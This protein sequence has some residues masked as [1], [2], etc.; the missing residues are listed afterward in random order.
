MIAFDAKSPL[1]FKFSVCTDKFDISNLYFTSK[2]TKNTPLHLSIRAKLGI[3]V[4]NSDLGTGWGDELRVS[5]DPTVEKFVINLVFE[6][7]YIALKVGDE[8]LIKF[9]PGRFRE[10][11]TI[12]HLR[13]EGGIEADSFDIKG[14]VANERSGKAEIQPDCGLEVAGWAFDPYLPTQVHGIWVRKNDVD[15]GEYFVADS[16]DLP[17][18]ARREEAPTDRIAFRIDLPG[19][20][21]VGVPDDGPIIVQVQSN[22]VNCGPQLLITKSYVLS[23]LERMADGRLGKVDLVPFLYAIEHI[24]FGELLDKLTNSSRQYFETRAKELN[25][26]EFLHADAHE[27]AESSPSDPV[28]KSAPVQSAWQVTNLIVEGAYELFVQ[29]LRQN[30]QANVTQLL[31]QVLREQLRDSQSR[32]LFVTMATEFLLI[33]NAFLELHAVASEVGINQLDAGDTLWSRSNGLPYVYM[34]GQYN[35]VREYMWAMTSLSG[36]LATPSLAWTMRQIIEGES[37]IGGRIDERLREEIIYAYISIIDSQGATYWGRSHCVHLIRVAVEMAAKVQ[38]FSEYLQNE[39]LNMILRNY[40]LSP[41]FYRQ[42]AEYSDVLIP[43]RIKVA[44]RFFNALVDRASGKKIDLTAALN[45]FQ[46]VKNPD[47]A[48]IQL[49]TCGLS[50]AVVG[51][52]T[53]L[54]L[55]MVEEARL[56]SPGILLRSMA[57]PLAHQTGDSDILRFTRKYID[58]CHSGVAKAP[59]YHL[60]VKAAKTL[61]FLSDPDSAFPEDF[62]LAQFCHECSVLCHER[63][64]YIGFAILLVLFDV[65]LK[66]RDAFRARVL[67]SSIADNLNRLGPQAAAAKSAPAVREARRAVIRRQAAEPNVNRQ[68]VLSLFSVGTS[69][70][71]ETQSALIKKFDPPHNPV[72]DTIVVVFSCEPYLN[73]RITELRKGWLSQLK[74]LGVPYIIIT[75]NGNGQ[76]DGDVVRLNAADNYE[77]LPE[78][79]VRAVEWVAQN[80]NFSYMLKIDDDCFL[81]VDEYFH[82]LSYR[83]FDYYGRKVERSLGSTDRAWHNKKSS[84]ER[85]QLELDKS[86]EPSLYA[87]GG[88]GYALSRTAMEAILRVVE[89]PDGKKLIRYSFMEDKLIGD[90]LATEGIYMADE[91]YYVAVQRRTHSKA[92]P[93][94]LW[95]NSFWPSQASGTKLVHLDTEHSQLAAMAHLNDQTLFPRKIW[96][97]Y[98][99]PKLGW[100]CN[101]LELVSDISKIKLATDSKVAVVA[102]VRNEMFMLP[103]FLAH[104]RALGVDCFIFVDNI[105]DDGT[106]EY[107]HEQPDTVVFSVDTEYSM[108][109][110]G[111]AWQQALLAELRQDK[112]SIVADAD[113]LLVYQGWKTTSLAEKITQLDAS[114][115]NGCRIFMLDMYPEGPLSEATFRKKGPFGEASCVDAEPFRLSADSY[116]PYSNAPTWTSSL[117]HR[118]LPGSPRSLFVAQKIALLKYKPWMRLSAGLHYAAEVDVSD[119]A[120]L[121]AHFKYN[122]SFRAKALREVQRGQHFNNAEEYRKYAALMAEGRDR[123]YDPSVSVHWEHC[124][125]V[126]GILGAPSG[127]A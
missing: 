46:T 54:T 31:R 36:W 63:S 55:E 109:Q 45:F 101:A 113:E 73:T 127:R 116:G 56:K 12:S 72:F 10:I 62:D 115:K 98:S 84:S 103:H 37:A 96:P 34:K 100:N 118:L 17:D 99:E 43:G 57:S 124:D 68:A 3:I 102:C 58:H 104:Y 117:R 50:S 60:Q 66:R 59:Y 120:M 32:Q 64:S 77:G 41:E 29:T 20:I 2:N 24:R 8:D 26:L 79:T 67:L 22:K 94:S 42:L 114:G 38:S 18:V 52:D 48:R 5:F 126:Q 119:E 47:I 69:D 49:E 87:D 81:N 35:V 70:P 40:G 16:L 110:Y 78:K 65:L 30:P 25:V 14:S 111:V 88:S 21:W 71:A 1:S 44:R 123:I 92:I 51:S 6:K 33:R 97:T 89:R 9:A 91:D 83:K 90:L 95:G 106:L 19:R 74:Q 76:I 86:P 107:L 39:I 23:Y 122:S 53:K 27:D 112:W 82:S 28:V 105:S 108:S 4:L 7:D 85:G 61:D 15:V 13:F 80:T 125:F 93:V 75:G 11:E 121:F